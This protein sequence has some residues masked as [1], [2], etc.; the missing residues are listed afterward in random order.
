MKRS[1]SETSATEADDI[2]IVESSGSVFDDL[3]VHLDPKDEL[4]VAIAYQICKLINDKGLTQQQAA[5]I[6]KTDQAK[7]S[8]VTRGRLTGFSVDR[9]L[10]FVTALGYDVDVSLK[11]SKEP[12]GKVTVYPSLVTS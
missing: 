10:N 7:I 1:K 8:A 6:L 9:L 12:Q 4:K 5:K 11:P 3:D 2:V